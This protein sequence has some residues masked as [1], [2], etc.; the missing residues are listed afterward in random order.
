MKYGWIGIFMM[1]VVSCDTGDNNGFPLT[2][3]LSGKW[4][5]MKTRTDTLRFESWESLDVMYLGRGIEV[6]NGSLLP[7]SGSGPYQY[8][9]MDG[10]ISLNWMLSSNSSFNDYNFR[11]YGDTLM[12][13]NFYGS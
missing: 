5:E 3:G 9:L 1:T 2:P 7:K 11:Y 4:V 8:K 6:R 13:D 12:I 10:K